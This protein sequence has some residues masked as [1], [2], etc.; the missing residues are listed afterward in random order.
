M[1]YDCFTFFNELDLLEI[2]LQT[3]K[4]VVDT[5]VVA[6]ATR[7][8]T[9]A[10]KELVFEKFRDRFAGFE[11]RIVYLVV[12]DL[13][14][15]DVVAKDRY[16]LPWVNENRQRNALRA[17]VAAAKPDDIV[18]ISDVD[19][20]P[21]PAAV[22]A[23][24]RAIADGT[25]CVRLEMGFYNYYA[26][27]K[28]HSCPKWTLGTVAIRYG[29][30]LDG[31]VFRGQKTDRYMPPSE[32]EGP[33]FNRLRFVRAPRTI[34]HGG[35]HFSYLGGIEA[36]R[37]K[38]AAFSHSEFAS[39]PEKILKE[40]LE[41]GDDLFGRAGKSFGVPL[42]ETFPPYL[43]ENSDRFQHLIFPV[44][45][46]YLSKTKTARRLSAVKGALYRRMVAAV[47]DR[48]ALTLVK[49]RDA[50]QKRLGRI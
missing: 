33:T 12:D 11:D 8:H 7:T 37:K 48:L 47:P 32:N 15:E 19:E 43:R 10:R 9:G 46:G 1:T 17:G 3:L 5:F 18:M 49:I 42:D 14:P 41:N 22:A 21:S 34:A 27:F 29:A 13:L 16:R 36:I 2:R 23:A 39:V 31:A 30:F 26:N 4:N 20:I 45:D 6:E 38:I 35:W 28:N 24:A 25:P 50:V 44:D 40:R